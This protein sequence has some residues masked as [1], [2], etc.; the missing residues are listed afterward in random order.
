MPGVTWGKC[1]DF[2]PIKYNVKKRG[3]C[4][5]KRAKLYLKFVFFIVIKLANIF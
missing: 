3:L 4:E 2:E 1:T 5:D